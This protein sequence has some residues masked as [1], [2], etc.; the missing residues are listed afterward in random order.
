[1]LGHTVIVAVRPLHIGAQFGER[2]SHL[3]VGCYPSLVVLA[4][5]VCAA[6]Q[7]GTVEFGDA[8]VDG[9]GTL[10][11]AGSEFRQSVGKCDSAS[12]STV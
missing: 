3:F 11:R 6:T 4:L 7:P 2:F 12:R 10:F 1:M 5:G 9:R 8:L